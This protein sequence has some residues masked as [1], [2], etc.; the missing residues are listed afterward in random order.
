MSLNILKISL[1]IVNNNICNG[2]KFH[3]FSNNILNYYD[4]Y[5]IKF[6][7]FYQIKW[8]KN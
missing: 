5:C 4:E 8:K 6:Q 3:V 7:G 2:G 1:C